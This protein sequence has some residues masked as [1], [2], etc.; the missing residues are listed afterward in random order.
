M[1]CV[2]RFPGPTALGCVLAVTIVVCAPN[3]VLA[4]SSPGAVAVGDQS[5]ETRI[6]RLE[7]EIELLKRQQHQVS[8]DIANDFES[9]TPGYE[10]VTDPGLEQFS[11]D[12]LTEILQTGYRSQPPGAADRPLNQPPRLDR[13]YESQPPG[14]RQLRVQDSSDSEE[15]PTLNWSGFLQLDTAFVSQDDVNQAS[16]GEVEA[17]TGLRRVRLRA[18]GNVRANSTYVIDLDFAASGHPSFRNV[19]LAFHEIPMLQNIQMGYFKN[20]VTMQGMTSGRQLRFLE[21]LLPFAFDP[22]R[23][24]G[25]GAYGNAADD[26]VSWSCSSFGY[27]TDSF[28]VTVGGGLGSSVSSRITAI[29]LYEDEGERIIHVGMGYSFGDPGNDRVRYSI[30]P[31]FFV[32]DP[33][34]PNAE[35]GV[36]VFVD[37]GEIPARGF[38][39]FNIELANQY[40][41]V[42]VHSE[43]TFA[44]VDQIG[45]PTTSFFGSYFSLGYVLTGE[46]LPYNKLHGTFGRVNPDDPFHLDHGLGAW[47]ITSGCS[48]IDLNDKNINGGRMINFIIGFNWY[49]SENSRFQLNVIPVRLTDPEYGRSN[50]AAVA[51]RAQVEF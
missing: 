6:K 28:G 10:T 44:V 18:D 5:F 33:G 16:V 37:T 24:T 9:G 49:V 8:P 27:P 39:I 47:E 43:S 21:R 26:R 22:F 2:S 50:A 40:G 38:H 45:G 46:I 25:I 30:Q 15:F 1:G 48:Y 19:L 35:S 31:G 42:S 41:A 34:N 11:D 17:Q 7:A 51:L 13:F 12:D 4:Q 20:S 36:P 32:T 23:Q 3:W 29:P 14:F